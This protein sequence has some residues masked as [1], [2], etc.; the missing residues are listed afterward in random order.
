[1]SDATWLKDKRVVVTRPTAQAGRLIDLLREAG[2]QV[3]ELPTLEIQPP[4][5]WAPL[6]EAIRKLA[7]GLYHWVAF[8]SVNGVSGFFERLEHAGRDA[9]TFGRTKI[10]AV[11]A[12]TARALK[13]RGLLAD[14]TP[15]KFSGA[16]LARALGHG[17]GTVLLPRAAGAPRPIV[18]ALELQGWMVDEVP[19]YVTVAPPRN[20]MAAA[21]IR[22]K[23]FDVV[24]FAS[25]SAV[26]GLAH[27]VGLPEELG[28]SDPEEGDRLVICIGPV[29]AEEATEHGFRVDMVAEEHTDDG[30][31]AA[32]RTALER[33]TS[34]QA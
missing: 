28:L 26:R 4:P 16:D 11:G 20:T 27:L 21:D 17:S 6:D 12:T 19:A 5:T 29:T 14:L 23:R 13:E 22:A 33:T 34:F 3:I 24:T 2:A 8:T 31:V 7:G 10:A 9:R 15:E 18:E 32:I 30:L 1:M 25:P